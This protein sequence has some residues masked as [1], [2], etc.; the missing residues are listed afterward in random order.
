ME[1]R[2]LRYF[3]AVAREENITRAAES[4]HIT[5]PSLSKQLMD[6]EKELGKQLLIR[7][8]RKITLTEEGVLLRK[9]AEE[10]IELVEKTEQE[11]RTD[12]GEVMGDLYLGGTTPDTILNAASK[13]RQAHPGVKFHFYS[14]DATDVSERLNHGTLDFAVML[15]PIDNVKYDFLSLPDCSEWGI[16]V[17]RTDPLS[18]KK[19]ITRNDLLRLPLIMHQRVGLQSEIAHWAGTDLESLNVAATYNVVHGTPVSFVKQ[20]LG[21][22]L[23]TRDLLAPTL[24][25]D[26]LF[27]PLEP[28]LPTELA[29]VWKK[30]AVFSKAARI[31]INMLKEQAVK[32]TP[33]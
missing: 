5:Q 19:S 25:P 16:L 20:K 29:L 1:I 12:F 31:F 13:L 28:K 17:N 18:E 23:T 32:S 8:K 30:H 15:Q 9:R 2:E 33:K 6:L 11:I 21:Y 4:L 14:G 22:F 10:I 7:G 26:V 3:L 27:L 24:D